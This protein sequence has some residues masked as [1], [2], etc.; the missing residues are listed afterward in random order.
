MAMA[1]S[2]TRQRSRLK[3]EESSEVESG[4]PTAS[5]V[6]LTAADKEKVK[7]TLLEL[8]ETLT[9]R[10]R[11][12]KN[13]ALCRH[14]P[15]NPEEDG[16]EEFDRDFA[17]QLA[18]TNNKA[19]LEIDDALRRVD[20]GVY[21]SCEQCGDKISGT[22]LQAVPFVKTCIRCQSEIER[23]GAGFGRRPPRP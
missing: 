21:G 8:R 23:N 15:V 11:S 5:A 17:L 13:D 18:T 16:T 10:V 2:S 12:L 9:G 6:V 20:D 19:L 7:A 14:D 3:E 22:R 1:T 4:E